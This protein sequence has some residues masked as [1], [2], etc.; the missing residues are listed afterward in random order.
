M[1][2]ELHGENGVLNIRQTNIWHRTLNLVSDALSKP[3]HDKF[4]ATLEVL[5]GFSES[6]LAGYIGGR[7]IDH[8]T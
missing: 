5:K 1:F 8:D 6:Q 4:K 3:D 7:C 2:C